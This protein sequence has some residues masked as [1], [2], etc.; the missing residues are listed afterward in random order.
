MTKTNKFWITLEHRRFVEFCEAC[1]TD[2][3]IGVCYGT[4]GVGKTMSAYHHA[5][6][7][8]LEQF[9]RQ[10]VP[11]TVALPRSLAR[12]PTILYTPD[13]LPTPKRVS[14]E[15]AHLRGLIVA[16]YFNFLRQGPSLNS[17][18]RTGRFV[19]RELL[20][21]D[22]ADR[23]NM[24]SIEQVRDIYDHFHLAV[25]FIGMPGLEKRL[26]RYPQLYSRVGF[27]HHFRTLTDEQIL[28]FI[29]DLWFRVCHT[30]I[31]PSQD[32]LAV[33]AIIRI[34]RG[35]LRLLDR[36]FKQIRRVLKINNLSKIDARVVQTAR[37]SL[38]LGVD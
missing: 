31:D 3:T 19:A 12:R 7:K 16:G 5:R 25:V 11:M 23:L 30:T 22:E 35:N 20:I 27:V 10:N 4:P 9:T 21:I 15:I 6:W 34:T 33:A 1:R 32:Q 36:L 26:M 37:E 28:P 18:R 14:N 8:H 29:S 17:D 2:R 13:I 24:Q 38:V